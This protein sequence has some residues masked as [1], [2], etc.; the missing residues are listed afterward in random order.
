ME[1]LTNTT[2]LILKCLRGS[3]KPKTIKNT[4]VTQ[5][6]MFPHH[7]EHT[8]T[9]THTHT[10]GIF[11]SSLRRLVDVGV[12]RPAGWRGS[13]VDLWTR[14][15]LFSP[16]GGNKATRGHRFPARWPPI[17]WR[18]E[19]WRGGQAWW[20]VLW[21]DGAAR[22]D[23]WPPAWSQRR[24]QTYAL[25]FFFSSGALNHQGRLDAVPVHLMDLN[26]CSVVK[27]SQRSCDVTRLPDGRNKW[28]NNPA[29][30]R[31]T[32]SFW[33]CSQIWAQPVCFCFVLVWKGTLG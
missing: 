8:H 10:V 28:G 9:H 5:A 17:V 27:I 4:S 24:K 11:I 13:E 30:T 1:G 14:R 32:R 29:W 6:D 19:K 20:G 2:W 25:F 21:G 12:V 3:S 18:L 15:G 31:E 7:H 22:P 23:L 26:F 33:C 16:F